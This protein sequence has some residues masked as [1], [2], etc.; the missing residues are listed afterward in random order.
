MKLSIKKQN[1][2]KQELKN[3]LDFE[4]KL[5]KELRPLFMKMNK[6]FQLN[7]SRYGRIISFDQ[8]EADVKAILRKHYERVQRQF[9]GNVI[10]SNNIDIS[11]IEKKDLGLIDLAL[12]AWI[13]NELLIKPRKIIETTQEGAINS[14][15]QAQEQQLK[16]EGSVDNATV[17]TLALAFNRRKSL[18]RLKTIAI[19]E[20]QSVSEG[21]KLIQA[22]ALSGITPFSLDEDPFRLT[23]PNEE[24]TEQNTKQWVTVRDGNVRNTHITADKQTVDI[25]KTFGVGGYEMNY[26]ADTSLGAPIK[27]TINCRCSASYNIEGF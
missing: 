5:I 6:A 4:K 20:T 18:G 2:A 14:V 7:Y 9:S 19:T 12:I 16:E 11:K 8:Y 21:S 27:E 22:Q 17:A 23:R 25:D 3:K 1:I 24:L 10:K 13:T 15:R 26:P